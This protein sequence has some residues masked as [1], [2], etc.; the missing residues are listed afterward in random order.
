[1]NKV[2]IVDRI[3]I[4]S[5]QDS[6]AEVLSELGRTTFVE[7]FAKDNRSE[8]MALYLDQTFSTEKQLQEL[9]DP[10]RR[11]EIAWIGDQPVGFFQ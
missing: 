5:A 9:R 2:S 7:T 3:R 10:Q 1:M 6:D 4:I 11:I 8:D